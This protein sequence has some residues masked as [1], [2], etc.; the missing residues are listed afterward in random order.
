MYF[1]RFL[2]F[3]LC[4]RNI[5]TWPANYYN[6]SGTFNKELSK[7]KDGVTFYKMVNIFL[8]SV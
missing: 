3:Y 6:K 5:A 4:F 1:I 2:C 7:E 8:I